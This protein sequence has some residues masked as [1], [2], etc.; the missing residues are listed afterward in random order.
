VYSADQAKRGEVIYQGAC[1]SC[2][3]AMLDGMDTAPALSG[4]AFM[5]KWDSVN[6][7]DMAD[8]IRV[9]MPMSRPGSLGRQQ[10]VD[11]LAYM[12]S[13]NGVPPGDTELTP[14]S[15]SLREIRFLSSKP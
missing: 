6:L 13:F 7:A 11:V 1:G 14:Q 3:G 8:R 12:L 5:A 9:T 10:V 15:S 2:H 4:G